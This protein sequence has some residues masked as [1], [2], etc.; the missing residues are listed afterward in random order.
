MVPLVKL[1]KTLWSE[2]ICTAVDLINLSLAY[3]MEMEVAD[4]IWLS[5]GIKNKHVKVFG[6]RVIAHVHDPYKLDGKIKLYIKLEIPHCK[7]TSK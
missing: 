6:C 2:A 7:R 1:S 4:G 3:L 5:K